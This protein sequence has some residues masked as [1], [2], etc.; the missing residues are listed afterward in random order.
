MTVSQIDSGGKKRGRIPPPRP[1]RPRYL[2]PAQPAARSSRPL[3][4]SHREVYRAGNGGPRKGRDELLE[5]REPPRRG[6]RPVPHFDG[7]VSH[8]T[9][10]HLVAEKQPRAHRPPL[11]VFAPLLLP[12]LGASKLRCWGLSS[13][14][15]GSELRP[16]S[17]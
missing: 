13:A 3:A 4:A 8:N 12:V 1:S 16:T 10:C 5:A 6:R 9:L 17:P 2:R 11:A 15:S 14:T 7:A